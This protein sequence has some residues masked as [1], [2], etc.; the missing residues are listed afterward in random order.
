MDTGRQ[1]AAII[2]PHLMFGLLILLLGVVFALDNLDIVAARRILDYWPVG[3]IL[4]GAAKLWEV[5][6]G[7]G[8]PVGGILFIA[9]GGWLLL[10]NLDLIDV[11]L[12]AFWPVLLI[13]AGAVI[14]VQGLK[15]PRTA[16][17]VRSDQTVSAIAVM[18]GVNRGSN[19][20]NFRGGELAAFMGGCEIDL[21]Q[22]AI[23]GEAVI[24]VF[25]MWGGIEIRV[26]ENW[27]VIGRVMPLLGGFDD[28]TRPPKDATDHRLI[29]RGV[30]LMGG[31]EVKN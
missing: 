9:A 4:I 18:S 30:V 26:P 22:A 17:A 5:R 29:V 20:S 8:R 31:V 28:A 21:R 7:H 14:V 13:I 24:D 23:H 19:T 2:T 27:T 25:A 10:D 16:L 3:L 6:S 1:P 11:S 15:R 12:F